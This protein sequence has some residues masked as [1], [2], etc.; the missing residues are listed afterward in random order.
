MRNP[1]APGTKITQG[2]KP[3]HLG[4]DWSARGDKTVFAPEA[5]RLTYENQPTAGGIMVVIVGKT[6]KHKLAHLSKRIASNGSNVAEG[7]PVGIMGATGKVTGPHLHQSLYISGK[8]VNPLDYVTS[9][10]TVEDMPTTKEVVNYFKR[11]EGRRPTPAEDKAY[12]SRPWNYLTD[13]LLASKE[14]TIKA[15]QKAIDKLVAESTKTGK[16]AI[17]AD[18]DKKLEKAPE[19]SPSR[20][21]VP[22]LIERFLNWLRRK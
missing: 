17:V 12:T 2:Y 7:Q 5:G 20:P 21:D 10:S 16:E 13:K 9:G 14:A 6:G 1:V 11:W 18:L 15:Q 22:D 4:I 19:V 3:T 8:R